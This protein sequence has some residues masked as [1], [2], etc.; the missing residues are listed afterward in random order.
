MRGEH[1]RR[2]P[3]RREAHP[4]PAALLEAVGRTY[5]ERSGA[6]T[7]GEK[8]PDHLDYVPTILEDF[9]EAAILCIV[10]DP[11]DVCLSLRGMPWNR[12]SLLESAWKWRRY[13]RLVDQYKC[14]Y[15]NHFRQIRYEDLLCDAECVIR[16]I[17]EWLNT[18]FSSAVFDF[19]EQKTSLVD[20]GREPWKQKV[21]SPLDHTNREKWRTEMGPAERWVVQQIT[22]KQ[23]ENQG[24]PVPPVSRDG[25]FLRELLSI[26]TRTGWMI[27]RRI[28]R[29]WATPSRHP[30][31]Y[32]P[33]W[34]RRKDNDD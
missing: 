2:V 31:D 8:T 22:G 9:P 27:G 3:L 10:R 30:D 20:A 24:Y 34:I 17:L 16:D 26:L 18:P 19:H 13:A 25:S 23:L 21:H 33:A 29:R 4:G 14:D 5:A 11:R 32:R 28:F 1:H 7:W 15:P 12:D 6:E